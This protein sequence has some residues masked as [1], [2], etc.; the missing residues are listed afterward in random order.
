M[1]SGFR[2][3]VIGLIRW[4]RTVGRQRCLATTREDKVGQ[5]MAAVYA[6]GEIEWT[7]T[8]RTTLAFRA[9]R[10]EFLVTSINPLNS[11]N[12]SDSLVSPKLR[13]YLWTVERH[14][15]VRERRHRLS[16]Q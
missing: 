7:R 12:G 15:G 14:R 3:G 4:Y 11:G 6:Q 9:D 8:F 10:Y 16:Q 13:G 5:T 1:P 2:C